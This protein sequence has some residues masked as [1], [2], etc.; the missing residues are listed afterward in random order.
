M[1]VFIIRTFLVRKLFVAPDK[2][3]GI[4]RLSNLFQDTGFAMAVTVQLVKQK[5]LEELGSCRL[6]FEYL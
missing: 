5:I 2:E 4:V 3:I 6:G 1:T